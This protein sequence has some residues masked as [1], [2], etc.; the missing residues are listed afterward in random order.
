MNFFETITAAVA[1]FS[2]NGY[3]SEERLQEWMDRI[4]QAA[5]DELISEADLQ[6]RL[7]QSLGVIYT[8]L[9]DQGAILR[10][11][12]G[13][14]RYTLERVRPE[15]RL[16]LNRRIL[17][18]ASLIRLNREEAINTTLS[19]FAGWATSVP[20]GGAPPGE[21]RDT[22]TTLRK[23]LKQLAFRDRRV[24]IDQG[25]KLTAAISDVVARGSGAIALVWHQH[26]TRFPRETHTKRDGNIYLLRDSWAREQ[27]LVKPGKDGF[28]DDITQPGFEVSCRCTG[29]YITN[30]GK[31]PEDMLTQKGKDELARIRQKTAA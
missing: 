15:L 26:Y 30:P 12:P 10:Q 17:A 20:P 14:S 27:G 11:Q 13:V 25:H 29:T 23:E 2:E 3:D 31:L 18:N 8:R 1:D 19:R 24:A 28:L 16:E 5:Q 22:T 21:R 4:R 9:V 7:R 6:E